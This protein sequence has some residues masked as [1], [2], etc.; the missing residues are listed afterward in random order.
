[1]KNIARI[2]LFALFGLVLLSCSHKP[3]NLIEDAAMTALL[4]DAYQLEGFYAVERGMDSVITDP[5]IV[6]TYD[7]IFKKHGVTREQFDESMAYYMRHSEKYAKIH[8]QVVENLDNK[9]SQLTKVEK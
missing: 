7:S 6:A 5:V 9:I 2:T 8:K 3:K 1:M 4:T